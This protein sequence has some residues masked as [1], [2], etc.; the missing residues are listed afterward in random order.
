[1]NIGFISYWGIDNP[2]CVATVLPH[3]D[4]LIDDPRVS[5]VYLITFERSRFTMRAGD[6]KFSH[7]PVYQPPLPL[8][9]A[10]LGSYLRTCL[11]LWRLNKQVGLDLVICRSVFAG[12]LGHFLHL[13]ASVPYTVESFEPHA[14]YM[15]DNNVWSERG[16][17]TRAIRAFERGVIETAYRLYPVADNYRRRLQSE[18][19]DADKLEVLPCTTDIDSFA[20]SPQ[21][22]TTIRKRLRIPEEAIVGVYVG[23]FGGM[24]LEQDALEI[25]QST[26]KFFDSPFLI[27]LSDPQNPISQRIL[28]SRF[29]TDRSVINLVRPEDVPKYLCAADFAFATYRPTPSSQYLSPVKLGEYW[30]NGLPT[31]ITD[32][33]GDDSHLVAEHELG[34]VLKSDEYDRPP[35]EKLVSLKHLIGERRAG[36]SRIAGFAAQRRSRHLSRLAYGRLVSSLCTSIENPNGSSGG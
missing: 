24:Y 2:L 6:S 11:A 25:F 31:V 32:G 16:L 34:I 9:L 30:A 8:G 27:V 3:V 18:G 21:C 1:M 19:A 22:R 15:V 17:K 5:N 7:I 10:F 13:S 4:I 23:K 14:D 12:V 33:I 26:M 29:F 36:S 28:N 35:D 20:F